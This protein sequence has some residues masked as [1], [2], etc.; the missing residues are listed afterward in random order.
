MTNLTMLFM[1]KVLKK[2]GL[3]GTYL[4]IIKVTYDKPTANIILNGEKSD[5]IS[6]KVWNETWASSLSF[7]LPYNT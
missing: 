4:N 2:L 7:L 3:E 5:T 1:V 6:S